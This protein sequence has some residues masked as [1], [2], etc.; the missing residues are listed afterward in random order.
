M[1]RYLIVPAVAAI[2]AL[3]VAACGGADPTATPRPTATP[4][5]TATPAPT[6]TAVLT[7]TP[8]G[9]QPKYGG[10]LQARTFTDWGNWD[11]YNASGGWTAHF[12]MQLLSHLIVM[13]QGTIN[14]IEGDLATAWELGPDGKS[15]TFS[16]RKDAAFHD[17]M[18]VTAHDV[19]YNWARALDK[20]Q[21]R[22]TFNRERLAAVDSMEAPDDYT[23]SLRK[24][25]AFHD[26]MPVTA[27]DVMYNWARA[28]DKEQTRLTFNRERLAAVDSME[29]PDDY[30][31]KVQLKN[32]SASF[33]PSI[34]TP[35]MLVY[36]KHIPDMEEWQKRTPIGSGGFKFKNYS[37][38]VS[39]DYV[40][41]DGYY[42]KDEAGRALPYLDGVTYNIIRDP[43]FALGAFRSGKLHCGCAYDQD[44][45]TANIEELM[46]DV[47]G[48]KL[49]P[50][51][52]TRVGMRFN[53]ARAPF[54]NLA[55]RQGVAIGL[56]KESAALAAIGGDKSFWPTPPM[57]PSEKG[58]RWALPQEQ[59]KTIPGYLPDQA[60]NL[61]IAKQKFAESGIDP[62]SVEIELFVGGRFHSAQAEAV[63]TLISQ[64]L[65]V[66]MEFRL[67]GSVGEA[68]EK[69]IKG[70]FDANWVTE[71]QTIDDPIDNYTNFIMTGGGK[72]FGKYSNARVDEL[73][74]AQDAELDVMKRREMLWE[75][76]RINFTEFPV[77]WI[78]W[79]SQF[80]GTRPE[81]E[82][83]HV[84]VVLTGSNLRLDKVWLDPDLAQ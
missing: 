31:F 67:A 46:R 83:Y 56:D 38:D 70:D 79:L 55:F 58:G 60:K 66:R 40:R 77:V 19:M 63:A 73:L 54:D 43:S 78:N 57:I 76:Q 47:P 50:L 61:E 8:S 36:P 15:Y 69:A 1:R 80:R 51:L 84:G 64:D 74:A 48:A 35:F 52:G 6:P 30:T 23:F 75:V 20:E 7:P 49:E 21:T 16:L 37:A 68:T 29:A 34:A 10:V 17:G 62:K 3:I 12:T 26:G 81:V 33:L 59:I 13:E 9:P 41:N 11:T 82:G 53:A 18:P 32:V 42:K 2:V 71:S 4:L 44:F 24:D 14:K 65:G 39:Y 22:L 25:A 28:L 45:M 72:N 5:P 27:H